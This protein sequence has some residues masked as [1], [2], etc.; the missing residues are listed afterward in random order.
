MGTS[1][2]KTMD[3]GASTSTSRA[4]RADRN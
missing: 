3:A 2:S 4:A 1:G